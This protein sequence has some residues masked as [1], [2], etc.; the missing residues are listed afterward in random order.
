MKKYN[1]DFSASQKREL[2]QL[3]VLSPFQ[4][5]KIHRSGLPGAVC[6]AKS[7]VATKSFRLLR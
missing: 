4:I 3:S 6:F 1:F 5:G 7:K 2:F